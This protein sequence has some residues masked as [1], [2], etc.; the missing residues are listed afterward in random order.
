MKAMTRTGKKSAK[1]KNGTKRRRM[2]GK[3]GSRKFLSARGKIII[4][5]GIQPL[6]QRHLRLARVRGDV[7][8]FSKAHAP[9]D[10]S[11]G[12]PKRPVIPP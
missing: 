6:R 1:R 7:G 9:L 2:S 5:N 3:I 8:W 11:V 10:E 12:I 4:A